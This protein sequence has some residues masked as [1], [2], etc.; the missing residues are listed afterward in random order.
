MPKSC[1]SISIIFCYVFVIIFIS[2]CASVIDDKNTSQFKGK[3]IINE[4]NSESLS[5]NI[6]VSIYKNS[7]IIQ[8]KRPFYGNVLKIE[9]NQGEKA[10]IFT[11]QYA[12]QFYL[13]DYIDQNLRYWLI[14]CLFSKDFNIFESTEDLTFK[15]LC[16]KNNDNTNIIIEYNEFYIEGFLIRQ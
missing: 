5:F 1:N 2:S 16:N 12:N 15:F 8:I 9:L 7:S 4:K 3:V 10:S 11:T 13:P 14:Q 6:N